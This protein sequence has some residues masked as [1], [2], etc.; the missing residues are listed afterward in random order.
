MR[1]AVALQADLQARAAEGL[2]R[3][4]HCVDS[5]QGVWLERDGRRWL[6]FC[7][8]DYLGLAAHPA[9]RAALQRGTAD[10]GVGSG[11]S[12]L[13]CGHT[14]AHHALEEELADFVGRERALLF[15]TG[16]MANLGVIA[17]L[18]G[19]GDWV[20]EDK[21]N[22]ASLIDGARLS[23][24]RL[25]RYAHNDATAAAARLAECGKG[26]RLLVSD[27]L[28]S[29]DGDLAPLAE[30]AEAAHN[31]DAWL[32]LDDA[33]GLGVLGP[34]GRGSVAQLGLDEDAVPILIGTLGKAC[35]TFGAFVAGEAALIETLLQQARTA[36]YT[37]AMPAA[38][39]EATRA[40]LRIVQAAEDRRQ[41][42][43]VLT[44]QFRHGAQALGLQLTPSVSP[45]QGVLLGDNARALAAAA[46]LADCGIWVSAIR[47]PTVPVGSARLR[48]TLTA[49]HTAEQVERL[50]EALAGLRTSY[51]D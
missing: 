28:F 17:A 18:C 20:V 32:M 48:I 4:R 31:A 14:R 21:L 23:G 37:T 25:L 35:G 2:Y 5:P 13:I 30:L 45:I 27:T 1:L 15:S 8:N 44:A 39:A 40:A 36:I 19:R 26:R 12:H 24:A 38:V 29:M 43:Q 3:R 11:A 41:H 46:H 51:A 10:W 22:H 16:Y 42:L 49:A 7:S 47:P 50:L 6:N 9:L 34:Q 33:H